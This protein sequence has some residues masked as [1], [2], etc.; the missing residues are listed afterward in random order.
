MV[1]Y[2]GRPDPQILFDRY[3]ALFEQLVLGGA[4]VI[5]ESNEHYA[6]AVNYA[7]AET[8][9]A[10]TERAWQ[11]RDPEQACLENLI[12]MAARD[13][14]YP[15]P[16]IPAQGYVQVSGTPLAPLPAPL[17]FTIGSQS[18]QTAVAAD[19]PA[20]LD[21]NGSAT[22]RVVALT[23]GAAGNLDNICTG[24]M[25]TVV[26]NVNS[27]VDVLGC[28]FCSGKDAESEADF[29]ARY[30]SRLQYHPRATHE[31]ITTKLLE[32]PCATRALVRGGSCCECG[33]GE[34]ALGAENQESGD[35]GCANCGGALQF[36]LMFDDT[37]PCG[38]A[39]VNVIREAEAWLF[40]SPQGYG[41]G[42]V[43]I[44][45][46]GRIYPVKPIP[47]RVQ[48]TLDGCAS[49]GAVNR[50]EPIVREFFQ[51]LVPSQ[52]A[53]TTLLT[54]SLR[55]LLPDQAPSVAFLLTNPLPDKDN[56]YETPCG[57]EP[58]CDYQLCFDSLQINNGTGEESNCA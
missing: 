1:G 54:A 16:A 41:L 22:I 25:T 7:M 18:Y 2:L 53:D 19:Q 4:A 21:S 43:E 44:G 23:A 15:R 5:P 38:I 52:P 56:V 49:P 57:I 20:A 10:I 27:G 58:N 6:V 11:E 32:W 28:G 17:A 31:W 8:F 46:C 14:V 51:T 36:Y 26:P 55:R 45:V 3:K 42:Q 48:V 39:P 47:I 9:Y 40:G 24:T 29:R 13:G 33:C 12:E 34:S 50:I 30:I 37:F 35:C